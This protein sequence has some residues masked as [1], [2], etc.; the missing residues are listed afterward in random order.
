LC[1]HLASCPR[2]ANLVRPG[3][4]ETTNVQIVA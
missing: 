2:I 3:T 1:R 4:A